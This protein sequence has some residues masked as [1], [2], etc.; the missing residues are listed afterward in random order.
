M[1]K[2]TDSRYT[3]STDPRAT[4]VAFINGADMGGW[5]DSDEDAFSKAVIDEAAHGFGIDPSEVEDVTIERV[6]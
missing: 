4:L 5:T 3:D 1:S 2:R 6:Q